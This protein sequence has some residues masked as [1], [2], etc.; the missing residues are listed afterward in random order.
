[1]DRST[2]DVRLTGAALV[3][4]VFGL[5]TIASGERVLFASVACRVNRLGLQRTPVFRLHQRRCH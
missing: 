2:R 3:A 1:M 5:L 4:V